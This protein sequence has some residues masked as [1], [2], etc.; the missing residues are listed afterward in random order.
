M[1]LE[2]DEPSRI[3]LNILPRQSLERG[4]DGTV[5]R[6]ELLV[7]AVPSDRVRPAPVLLHLRAEDPH[8]SLMLRIRSTYSGLGGWSCE[9]IGLSTTHG[10]MDL[11]VTP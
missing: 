8:G 6:L 4:E 1:L 7:N 5:G 10:L 9:C 11:S 2:F 3:L